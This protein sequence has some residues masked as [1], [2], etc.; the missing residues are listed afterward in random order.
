MPLL[1]VQT[2]QARLTKQPPL[3]TLTGMKPALILAL[4]L[5]LAA[6]SGRDAPAPAPV[7]NVQAP[8]ENTGPENTPLAPAPNLP[9]AQQGRVT[10]AAN[11]LDEAARVT[12]TARLAAFEDRTRHQ[13][14]IAT[15]P[16]LN[17]ADIGAY[18]RD[19]ANHWG[20]GRKGH[21]D[22]VVIL[23]A[24]ND[25]QVRIAVGYGLEKA[26]PETLCRQIIQE[27]ML[28]AFAGGDF[29][30]GLNKGLT[31]LIAAMDEGKKPPNE[32]P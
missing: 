22:G 15:T 7:Q 16:T 3:C 29:A 31:A 28:P 23:V 24:P 32:Q 5:T 1:L 30:G 20:I 2:L 26:L 13:V 27:H 25:K 8:T 6:C 21:D 18:T 19:L 10:D 14:A 11:I 12:L 4:S 17:G 9:L